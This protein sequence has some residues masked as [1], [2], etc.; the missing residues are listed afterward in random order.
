MD[1]YSQ[2]RRR[3][4][5]YAARDEN[6]ARWAPDRARTSWPVASSKSVQRNG[7][8]GTQRKNNKND[9]EV[10]APL[11]SSLFPLP[12]SLA[13]RPSINGSQT[14]R[15]HRPITHGDVLLHLGLQSGSGQAG[16]AGHVAG[17]AG[18]GSLG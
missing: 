3:A 13:P 10:S 18:R 6:L 12:S 8:K 5:H 2:P 15:R 14:R 7:R 9:M 11:P 1:A 17:D 16:G 4:M